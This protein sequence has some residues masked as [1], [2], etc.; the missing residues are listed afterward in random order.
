MTGIRV[1]VTLV[2]D[3]SRHLGTLIGEVDLNTDPDYQAREDELEA[4]GE[5]SEMDVLFETVAEQENCSVEELLNDLAKGVPKIR[6]D[7]GRIIFGCDCY[8]QPVTPEEEQLF[9][10]LPEPKYDE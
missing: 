3:E 8:W 2:E 10:F 1:G 5:D 7:D 4:S 6:L 9:R